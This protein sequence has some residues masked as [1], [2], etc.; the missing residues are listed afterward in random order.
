MYEVRIRFCKDG[1]EVVKP[2]PNDMEAAHAIFDKWV[3]LTD[4]IPSC[5]VAL[6]DTD[7]GYSISFVLRP[8]A[9]WEG[10]DWNQ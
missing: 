10:W 6:V 2:C 1:H 5:N 7:T 3:A 9:E 4:G 8:I